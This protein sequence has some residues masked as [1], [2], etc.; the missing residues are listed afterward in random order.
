[1]AT[2]IVAWET[3]TRLRNRIIPPKVCSTTVEITFH[4]TQLAVLG[5][6]W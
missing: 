1:M 2:R 3:S 5:V 6:R 4:L